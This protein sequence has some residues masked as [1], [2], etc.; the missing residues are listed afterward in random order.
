MHTHNFPFINIHLSWF[1]EQINLSDLQLNGRDSWKLSAFLLFLHSF[2]FTFTPSPYILPYLSS[3]YSPLCF[4]SFTGLLL[5]SYVTLISSGFVYSSLVPFS[6]SHLPS[7]FLFFYP[8]SL[9]TLS[10]SLSCIYSLLLLTVISID[11]IEKRDVHVLHLLCV[12]KW[13]LCMLVFLWRGLL[14]WW[15]CVFNCSHLSLFFFS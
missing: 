10:P 1:P 6:L 13:N 8:S 5:P 7:H 14:H 9:T 2:F 12:C 4:T 3:L 15:V 11:L